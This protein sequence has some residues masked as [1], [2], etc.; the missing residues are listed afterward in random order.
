MDREAG[1]LLLF[2]CRVSFWDDEEFWKCDC[3]TMLRRDLMS[4]NCMLKVAKNFLVFYHS[5]NNL[6]NNSYHP[7][8][9]LPTHQSLWEMACWTWKS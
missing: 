2:G 9:W 5:K 7:L 4:L 6:V 1:E 3:C 8:H